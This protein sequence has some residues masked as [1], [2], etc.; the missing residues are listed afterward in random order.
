MNIYLRT[1]MENPRRSL[2]LILFGALG[3]ALVSSSIGASILY[4]GNVRVG[5]DSVQLGCGGVV[6]SSLLVVLLTMQPGEIGLVLQ[7]GVSNSSPSS[8]LAARDVSVFHRS[9]ATCT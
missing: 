4:A 5:R 2:G 9:S 7:N 3:S 6:F 8:D 1:L